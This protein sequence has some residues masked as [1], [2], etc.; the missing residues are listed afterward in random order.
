MIKAVKTLQ[1]I[2]DC[3]TFD[4]GAKYRGFLRQCVAQVDDAYN[5]KTEYFRSHLGASMIG[6]KCM[7]E[8][9]YSFHW[10]KKSI[11]NG[12]MIRL[13]NRGHLEEAR[14]VAILMTIGC[15]VW[16]FDENGKQFKITGV[17]GHYGGSLDAVVNNC[18]DLEPDDVALAEFKTHGDKSFQKLKLEGLKEAKPEHY[19]Q[20]Q[21]YMAKYKL[22]YGLYLAVNKNDD[23]LY[24]EIITLDMEVC[25]TFEK[26]ATTIITVDTPPKKISSNPAWKDCKYCSYV[27]TCHYGKAP[28]KN[29]RTCINARPRLDDSRLWYCDKKHINLDSTQQQEVAISCDEYRAN[30]LIF[31]E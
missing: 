9:W 3:L 19:V 7:R 21:T 30:P 18:P 16:Q 11:N 2:E 24:G 17:F 26:R 8:L 4:Q 20:M 23:E 1:K 10:V 22:K 14:F 12:R 13:F 29:C 5:P 28:D 15:N 27:D 6:R 31:K 25:D